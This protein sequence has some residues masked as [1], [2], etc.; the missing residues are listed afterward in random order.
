MAASHRAK[1]KTVTVM[2]IDAKV[3]TV[4]ATKAA[5]TVMANKVRTRVRVVSKAKLLSQ[6]AATSHTNALS[7]RHS[8]RLRF[9]T[10]KRLN[11]RIVLTFAV[12]SNHL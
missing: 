11:Q 7:Q 10:L 3:A 6:K 1:A 9:Q 12:T 5:K 4:R 2:V 8:R